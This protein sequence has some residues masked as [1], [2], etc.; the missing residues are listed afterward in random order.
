M[1]L[2]VFTRGF[3]RESSTGKANLTP[4]LSLDDA[5]A[6]L[7]SAGRRPHGK[8]TILKHHILAC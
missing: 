3:K 8:S 6:T 5:L 7:S 2:L 4:I 1:A